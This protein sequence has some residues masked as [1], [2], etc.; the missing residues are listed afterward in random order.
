M[1]SI[2]PST[3]GSVTTVCRQRHNASLA[4]GNY[5]NI[6]DTGGGST[7]AGINLD[8]W[9]LTNTGG[10]YNLTTLTGRTAVWFDLG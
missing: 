1:T 6:N 9:G 5:I 2:G 4:A 3:A 7:P 8:N 10:T